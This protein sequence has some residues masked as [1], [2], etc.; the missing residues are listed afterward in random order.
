M[1]KYILILSALIFFASSC[2]EKE[3]PQKEIKTYQVETVTVKYSQVKLP[4]NSTGILAAK[5]ESKLSFKT[6][7][8]IAEINAD[9]GEFVKK[10]TVLAKLNLQ[11]IQ[12][13][14]DK[15]KFG[16]E[17]AKRDLDRVNRLFADSVATLEQSQD[18]KTAYEFALSNLKI[19]NFNL[20]YSKIVAPENGRILKRIAQENEIIGPGY[21]AFLFASE[22]EN[23]VLRVSVSDKDILKLNY[24]NKALVLFDAIKDSEIEGEI[25]EI[26]SMADPYTGTYEVE[27]KILAK[28]LKLKSGF[29]AKVQIIPE[30][31]IQLIEMPIDALIEASGNKGVVY[32]YSS[33]KGVK[34][35]VSIHHIGNSSVFIQD[36]L[37]AGEEVITK[38]AAYIDENSLIEK[39]K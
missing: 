13:N 28:E 25:S 39:S 20:N 21:P 12:A 10:G 14:V 17:K 24:G 34:R 18:V 4:V 1:K 27:I 3:L 23:W 19:A 22:K 5:S 32:I 8:V 11:E 33:D 37:S 7:G 2:K 6:G 30:E 16:V 15:A 26:A 35:N 9:E 31:S 38:G 36:G 29:I